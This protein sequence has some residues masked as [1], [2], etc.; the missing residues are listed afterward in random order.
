[1]K[2]NT[3]YNASSVIDGITDIL[4]EHR[5]NN[6][7]F[8]NY[9]V[10]LFPVFIRDLETSAYKVDRVN[11]DGA[12]VRLLFDELSNPDFD[13]FPAEAVSVVRR[14]RE[15]L[16]IRKHLDEVEEQYN[17]GISKEIFEFL[18]GD[19][20]LLD[21]LAD[22][23]FGEPPI[24]KVDR[25]SDSRTVIELLL[26]LYEAN[27]NSDFEGLYSIQKAPL[28]F[29]YELCEQRKSYLEDEDDPDVDADKELSELDDI[30]NRIGHSVVEYCEKIRSEKK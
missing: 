17:E 9:C 29:A 5:L 6:E 14:M 21:Y 22:G 23:E 10:D 8:I 13:I 19:D 27:K 18:F 3:F 28:M 25:T 4:E 2:D 16:R 30:I 20:G 1:M 7:E 11:N 12:P 26:D 24:M 15:V